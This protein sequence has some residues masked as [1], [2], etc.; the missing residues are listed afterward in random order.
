RSLTIISKCTGCHKNEG[1]PDFTLWPIGGE[2]SSHQQWLN[3]I[4]KSL[5]LAPN[6]EFSQRTMPPKN[7][8]WQPTI[9]ELDHLKKWFH[10][11]KEKK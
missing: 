2:W 9:Q 4:E 1:L 10:F 6:Q 5:G 11:L 7:S 8:L 3:K